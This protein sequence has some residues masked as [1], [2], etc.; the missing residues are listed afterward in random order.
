MPKGFLKYILKLDP[1]RRR[2]FEEL[3]GKI[4]T[5]DLEGCDV[6][7]IEGRKNLYRLRSGKWRFIFEKKD[8]YGEIWDID[9]R[10]DIYKKY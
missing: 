5:L 7:P 6:K 2:L 4:E 8:G 3:V 9:T 1:K 10:G